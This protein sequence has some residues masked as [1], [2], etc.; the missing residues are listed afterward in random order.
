MFGFGHRTDEQK[1]EVLDRILQRDKTLCAPLAE[2]PQAFIL[3][4]PRSDRKVVVV[5]LYLCDTIPVTDELLLSLVKQVVSLFLLK[6]K[7]M[8]EFEGMDLVPSLRMKN[9]E[10][11]RIVRIGVWRRSYKKVLQLQPADIYLY[12]PCDG[13]QCGWYWE[14]SMVSHT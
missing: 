1:Q 2:I 8:D 14:K 7:F 9:G 13:V 4:G 10:T 3:P 5:W 11:D 12:E 6:A